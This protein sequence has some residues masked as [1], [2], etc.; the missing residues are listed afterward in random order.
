[1]V[2]RGRGRRVGGWRRMKRRLGGGGWGRGEKEGGE[3]QGLRQPR[4]VF[5]SVLMTQMCS[6]GD[7]CSGKLQIP[8]PLAARWGEELEAEK[9]RGREGEKPE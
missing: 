6:C 9:E 4:L 3:E 5:R 2:D 7:G 1:M 8:R